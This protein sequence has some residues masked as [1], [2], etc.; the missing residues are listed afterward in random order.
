MDFYALVVLVEDH[1]IGDEGAGFP[2][3]DDRHCSD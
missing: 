3:V 2:S 1:D